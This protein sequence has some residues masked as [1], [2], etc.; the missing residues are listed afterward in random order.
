M[1]PEPEERHANL[2]GDRLDLVEVRVDLGAGLVQVGEGRAGELELAAG[3]ERDA[4][5]VELA[6][7]DVAGSVIGSQSNLSTRA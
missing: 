1:E 4:L 3:L 6:P 5:A 7:D 2:F